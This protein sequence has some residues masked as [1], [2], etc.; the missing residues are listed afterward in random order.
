MAFL[1]SVTALTKS[2][3]INLLILTFQKFSSFLI[4]RLNLGSIILLIVF[5]FFK[6]SIVNASNL[7][8]TIWIQ[9]PKDISKSPSIK[10]LPYYPIKKSKISLVLSGGGA[11]GFSHIG[12]LKALEEN[13]IK[14]DLIVGTSMGSIVGGFYCAGFSPDQIQRI[15]REI[16]W[17]NIISDATYRPNLFLSQ[18]NIPRHHILQLRFDGFVPYIPLSLT[19]G[20]NVYQLIYKRLLQADFQ[21]IDDFDKLRIPFRS[22]A[23][24]L[25]SGNRVVLGRGDLA[26]AIHASIAFPLLFAPVEYEGMRLVDGG[27]T[28][29]LPVEV[30]KNLGS[31]IV[32]AVD[33]TSP[34]REPDEM[35]A[36]WE[37]ADQVTTIMME[38]PTK[39]SLLKA[40]LAI[41]PDLAEYRAGDFTEIDSIVQIGYEAGLK[42]VDSLKNLIKIK[43]FELKGEN[44]V[45]GKIT[46]VKFSGDTS[47]YFNRL[48]LALHTQVDNEIDR[49]NVLNDVVNI[50]ESG[51]YQDVKA[52]VLWDTSECRVDFYLHENPKINNISILHDDTIPD[53]LINFISQKF[54]GNVLN[55]LKFLSEV[56]GLKHNF[57][58]KGYSLVEV[59]FIR[60]DYDSSKLEVEL[61][62]GKVD[63]IQIDGNFTTRDFVIFREFPL[64]PGDFFQSSL[65]VEGIQNIYSTGLF[66]RVTLNLD[67]RDDKNILTIKVKEKKY[68]LM[69]LG[70]HASLERKSEGYLEFLHDNFW[71][72]GVKFSFEGAIGDYLRY[73]HS[74]LFTTRLFKTYLT[75]RLSFYYKERHDR[76]Y[77]NFE[78]V[79]NYKTIRRGA[80]FIIGQQIGRLGLI[81]LQLRLES[82]NMSGDNDNFRFAEHYQL[83]SFTVR[84]EVDKRDRLP[85]PQ[86]GIYNRWFWESGNQRVLG[87]TISFTRIFIGLEGYY[88]FLKYLNY[89]PYIYAGSADLT[90]PFSEFFTF[91][92][93]NNFPGLHER[94]KFGRQFVMGGVEFRY[95]LN[96]NLPI[97]AFLL[98]NYSSGAA[99]ERPDEKIAGSDFYHSLSLSFALNSIMGPIKATYSHIVDNR[100]VFYLSMGFEF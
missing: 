86:K 72:S 97:E 50:Y 55:V 92:G 81:S 28:D 58:S 49:Y 33:A 69:R 17:N 19:Q 3:G 42:V 66:D 48:N 90:L 29:N 71:G 47:F 91:G 51:F 24:D 38:D 13:Q 87:G 23:T 79:G 8:D 82:I 89:H 61:D 96:W 41:I 25:I 73:A 85:F 59:K 100:N 45:F 94:E 4:R 63:S 60:F 80:K 39:E 6:I 76:L 77:E 62:K 70:G 7:A 36:P 14:F 64:K 22:I 34:L 20:Q 31:D 74:S 65:A 2:V 57:I 26:E 15:A 21:G 99:W 44:Q 46:E 88:Q 37:I 84:S 68:L 18:K 1:T 12:V 53:S 52:R 54:N 43:T 93:Q 27:I 75:S 5:L 98:T 83:R 32:V 10:N 40:D 9:L 11:R 30:A 35:N 67:H 78:N 56:E 16:D 95:K